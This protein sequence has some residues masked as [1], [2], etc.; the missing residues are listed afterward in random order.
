M[1]EPPSLVGILQG[2]NDVAV[3]NS[4]VH[5][6]DEHPPPLS[7][8]PVSKAVIRQ[9]LVSPIHPTHEQVVLNNGCWLLNCL[10]APGTYMS[11]MPLNLCSAVTVDGGECRDNRLSNHLTGYHG[12]I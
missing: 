8:G 5:K 10:T 4:H 3:D 7:D 11:G 9:E 6:E 1:C 2:V 12:V